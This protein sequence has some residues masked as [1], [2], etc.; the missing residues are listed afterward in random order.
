MTLVHLTECECIVMKSIW[1]A[2][3]DVSL[4][5]IVKILNEKYGKDWKR[6]TVSTFLLHLI[7]KGYLVSYRV[8]RVFYY[9]PEI[10]LKSFRRDAVQH[11]VRFWYDDDMEELREILTELE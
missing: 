7:Q 10:D 2:G 1:D 4:V 5:D 11:F 6:Q 9:H 3:A 8:G